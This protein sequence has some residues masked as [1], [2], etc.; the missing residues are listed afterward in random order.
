MFRITFFFSDGKQG[1]SETLFRSVPFGPLDR[2][3]LEAYINRRLELMA[4]DCRMIA[5]RQSNLDSKR[6]IT[7]F[8]MP[9]GGRGGTWA[10]NRTTSGGSTQTVETVPEDSFTA[11]LLR[12]TDGQQ[13]YRTFAMLGFPDHV[14]E[15]GTIPTN[16]E[17]LVRLRLNNWIAAL[18]QASMGGKFQN[19]A[20]AQGRISVFFPKTPQNRLVCLGLRGQIP[21]AGSLIQLNGVKPFRKLNRAWR[22][23]STTPGDDD[24]DGYIYLANSEGFDVF[25]AVS[26]G[27]YK[28]ATFTVNVLNSYSISR[29]TS[30]KCGIPFGTVRGR[31]SK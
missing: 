18:T 19:G 12:L 29:L 8:E 2:I 26:G 7:V 4:T 31:R 28:S 1:W 20:T 10:Y 6:D 27:T 3:F 23:A 22:V 11:L 30:R 16:E 21:A 14:F 5:V 9:V 15:A 13:N 24:A 25:G 17:A